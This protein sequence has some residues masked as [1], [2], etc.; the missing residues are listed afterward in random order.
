MTELNK[1]AFGGLLAPVVVMGALLFI[2]A[3]TLDYWQA[4]AFLT[5]FFVP[6]LAITVY[7]M[8]KDPKL[9]QRRVYAGATAEKERSQKIIQFVTSMGFIAM[10]VVP[11]L[12]HR[13]RWSE[14][15]PYATVAGDVLVAIGFFIVF[16]CT[17]KIR[18]PR[19]PSKSLPNRESY[20]RD[21]THSCAIP[22]M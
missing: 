3:W 19:Q 14:V 10:L 4:W 17:K 2:P 6:A 15:P 21:C 5:V 9:L 22:C 8:R 11:A 1:K 7:L 13:H 20:R 18:L 16:L 12:D